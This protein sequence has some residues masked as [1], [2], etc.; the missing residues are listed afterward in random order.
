[1]LAVEIF[2]EVG[3]ES[4]HFLP[5]VPEVHKCSRLHGHSFRVVVTVEGEPGELSGWVMDF[6]DLRAAVMPFVDQLDHRLLN[7]IEGL[8]N[9]TSEVLAKWLWDRL[10]P[11]VPELACIEV[12]E[13]CT[14]GSRYR[15][16]VADRSR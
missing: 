9:P 12:R 7:D 6:A 14:S 13:T 10:V 1:M 15:G 2:I 16:P 11:T 3:F 5:E 4:A 8:H